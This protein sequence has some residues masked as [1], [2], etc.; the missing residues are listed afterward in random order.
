MIALDHF[1]GREFVET[2]DGPNG[3]DWGIRLYGNIIIR[4]E[5]PD[6]PNPPTGL[7]GTVFS[8][9]IL[10]EMDTRLVFIASDGSQRRH[11]VTFN[12]VKYTLTDN[13]IGKPIYPQM[14]EE[15]VDVLPP[16]PSPERV[17]DG[18]LERADSPQDAS[19]AAGGGE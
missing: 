6:R 19:E 15:L 16:D 5:D 14:P 9:V 12:P 18:P 11:E 2:L 8:L 17:A 7:Q 1:Y 3:Y 10:S 13:I 4:N